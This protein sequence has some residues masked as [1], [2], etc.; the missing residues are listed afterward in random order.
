PLPELAWVFKSSKD[1]IPLLADNASTSGVAISMVTGTKSAGSYVSLLYRPGLTA[2]APVEL[3]K[4]VFPS[5]FERATSLAAKAPL[6][7]GLFS[8]TTFP[9]KIGATS[10]AT[11]RA[12]VSAGPPGGKATTMRVAPLCARAAEPAVAS[13]RAVRLWINNFFDME[14]SNLR[15]SVWRA[16]VFKR[17]RL[18]RGGEGCVRAALEVMLRPAHCS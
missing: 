7:P 15:R 1:S 3:R 5:G 2:I 11:T 10:F 18:G 4:P 9:P 16:R 13:K 12:T 6:A 14:V 17:H 8:T